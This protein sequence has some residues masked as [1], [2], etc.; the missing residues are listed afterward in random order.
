[1]SE[2]T[3]TYLGDGVYAAYDGEHIVL[4]TERDGREETIYLEPRLVTELFHYI[5]KAMRVTITV[6]NA[7]PK[8]R[9]IE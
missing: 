8:Q 5:E 4:T 2:L 9:G 1:M 3:R 6:K 7:P